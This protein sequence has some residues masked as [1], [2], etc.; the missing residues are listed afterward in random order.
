MINTYEDR[1]GFA[2]VSTDAQVLLESELTHGSA[3]RSGPRA[4]NLHAG[5]VHTPTLTH[6]DVTLSG[7]IC[8]VTVTGGHVLTDGRART[9]ERKST[10]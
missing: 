3:A 8:T 1:E 7:F 5:I 10:W 6:A 2:V 9:E 4:R